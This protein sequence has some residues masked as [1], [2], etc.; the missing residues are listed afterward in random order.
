MRTDRPNVLRP[1]AAR[2][3]AVVVLVAITGALASCDDD[4]GGTP[5]P[6]STGSLVGSSTPGSDGIRTG[7][8]LP[9][10]ATPAPNPNAG[11]D[12]A[13][14]PASTASP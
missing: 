3:T 12:G 14:A 4:G 8:S 6:S 2:I 1:S 13:P 7:S 11:G 9:P 5:A 10:Q